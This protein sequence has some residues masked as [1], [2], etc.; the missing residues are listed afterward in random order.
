MNNGYNASLEQAAAF[1]QAA[2]GVVVRTQ[3]PTK[4]RKLVLPMAS[5]GTVAAGSSATINAM[6]RSVFSKGLEAL[7][8]ECRLAGRRAGVEEDLWREIVATL[9]A[10]SFD[11]VGGNWVRTHATAHRRRHQEMV[12]VAQM[13]RDMGVDAP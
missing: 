4:A 1:K 13:L 3:E 11:E 5:T 12:Q 10:A 2:A 8:V 6:L 9:D 7:L